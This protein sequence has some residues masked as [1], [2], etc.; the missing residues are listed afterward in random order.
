MSPAC[1]RRVVRIVK[2]RLTDDKISSLSA[3]PAGK[4]IEIFDTVLPG[5]VLRVTDKGVKSFAVRYRHGSRTLRYT[6][7][8]TPPL[9]LKKARELAHSRLAMARQGQNPMDEK[10]SAKTTKDRSPACEKVVE[11]FIKHQDKRVEDGDLKPA[12]AA[13]VARLLRRQVAALWTGRTL[14]S[15]A[16]EDVSNLLDEIES[17]NTK[18]HTFFAL[19]SLFKWSKGLKIIDASPIGSDFPT[20]AK[21]MDRER[22]LEEREVASVWKTVTGSYSNYHAIVQLLIATGQRRDEVAQAEWAEFDLARELWT[23]PAKRTKNGRSH[24][25]PLTALAIQIVENIPKADPVLLF[26]GQAG[27]NKN[28]RQGQVRRSTFSGWSKSKVRLDEKSGVSSWRL[29]DIRRTFATWLATSGIEPHI[30]ERIINHSSGEISGVA[31]VYNRASYQKKMREALE[32]WSLHLA[33]LHAQVWF[34]QNKEEVMRA[35][36]GPTVQAKQ[37]RINLAAPSCTPP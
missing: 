9:K 5:L 7:G 31:A 19:R 36:R 18:R 37:M 17:L 22:V 35:I 28:Y 3:A 27:V 10:R 29:H 23:I 11:R 14:A 30:V 16:A 33:H 25:I 1:P 26:P 34:L 24:R 13:E 8:R 12:H 15:I 2:E 6:I 20:P 21:P 32:K 4:R